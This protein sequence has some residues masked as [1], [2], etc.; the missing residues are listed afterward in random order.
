MKEVK[1]KQPNSCLL[2]RKQKYQRQKSVK[3]YSLNSNNNAPAY[4]LNMYAYKN[5]VF[6]S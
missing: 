3:K 1:L 6:G 5:I 2:Q 4:D